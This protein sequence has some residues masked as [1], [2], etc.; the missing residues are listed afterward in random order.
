MKIS[1]LVIGAGRCED[2]QDRHVVL[3]KSQVLMRM[4]GSMHVE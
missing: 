4:Y 3:I 2:R 1:N